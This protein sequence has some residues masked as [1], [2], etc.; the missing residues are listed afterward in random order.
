MRNLREMCHHGSTLLGAHTSAINS[1][2]LELD[3]VAISRILDRWS[4][5]VPGTQSVIFLTAVS[6]GIFEYPCIVALKKQ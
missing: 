2:S 3:C 4:T 6:E 1:N 5:P